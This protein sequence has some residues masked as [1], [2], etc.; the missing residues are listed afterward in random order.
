MAVRPEQTQ[1][2]FDHAV[3]FDVDGFETTYALLKMK[4][5]LFS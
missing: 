3:S 5:S 2:A 1:L 4:N